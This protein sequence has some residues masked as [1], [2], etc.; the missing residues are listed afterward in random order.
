VPECEIGRLDLS[1]PKLQCR[2]ACSML[3]FIDG[4]SQCSKSSELR[5]CGFLP[6]VRLRY[7]DYAAQGTNLIEL[8]TC[9]DGYG[10]IRPLRN[11]LGQSQVRQRTNIGPP[12]PTCTGSADAMVG[13]PATPGYRSW[14]VVCALT[15]RRKM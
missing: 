2:S 15:G 3:A 12:L 14:Q 10:R 1:T 11:A 4:G 5:V 8:R 13:V 6:S 7:I 9:Y